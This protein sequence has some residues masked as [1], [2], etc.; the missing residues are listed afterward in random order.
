MTTT[1]LMQ[2]VFSPH[3]SELALCE[4][5]E[6][7]T[8]DEKLSTSDRKQME[9]ICRECEVFFE[10]LEF[11]DPPGEGWHAVGVFAAGEYFEEDT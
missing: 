7:F 5:D 2:P 6:R 4:G 9:A 10:C 11:H 1:T 8:Q 3:W